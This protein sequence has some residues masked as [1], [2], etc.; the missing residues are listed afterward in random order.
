MSPGRIS[1]PG[2][3][4]HHPYRRRA[5]HHPPPF[6]HTLPWPHPPLR[7]HR[8]T[9]WR[10]PLCH[11]LFKGWLSPPLLPLPHS[12][13]LRSP[14]TLKFK[15]TIILTFRQFPPDW[16]EYF[17][18]ANVPLLLFDFLD[19]RCATVCGKLH[20]TANRIFVIDWTVHTEDLLCTNPRLFPFTCTPRCPLNPLVHVGYADADTPLVHT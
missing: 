11:P 7:L 5:R 19:G 2:R 13:T 18:G 8:V 17:K 10:T 6:R 20:F 14:S 12:A 9:H 1:Q 3:P 16:L 15:D 4:C